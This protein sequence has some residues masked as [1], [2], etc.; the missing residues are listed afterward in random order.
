MNRPDEVAADERYLED[1]VP[2]SVREYGPVPVS[3]AEILEFARKYDP[4]PIHVDP[5]WPAPAPSAG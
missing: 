5:E 1:F 2:G 3:E 4:Q